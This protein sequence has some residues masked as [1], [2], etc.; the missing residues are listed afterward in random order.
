MLEKFRNCY[1]QGSLV[2]ELINIDRGLYIVRVS[3]EV[4]GVILAT[5]L[6]A[7][8][9]VETAE[10]RARVRAIETL[11]LEVEEASSK[12]PDHRDVPK[13][14]AS[15]ESATANLKAAK[16]GNQ[17]QIAASENLSVP[18]VSIL[19]EDTS[20][21][22]DSSVSP[23]V[24]IEST[25]EPTSLTPSLENQT[26]LNTATDNSE[27]LFAGTYDFQ[28]PETA[29]SPQ[30]SVDDGVSDTSVKIDFYAVKHETDIELQRLGWTSNEGRDFLKR[31]YG[32]PSR[33]RLTDE[34]L[35]E[36]LQHL[37]SLP[38]PE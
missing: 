2:G 36:F 33:L 3:I 13:I 11:K 21:A 20:P 4:E 5:G 32:K 38:T 29:T 23:V 12:I 14:Q 35:L 18:P 9:T 25:P 26:V 27:N 31:Q 8:D 28:A 1:P 24:E 7:A 22:N 16:N 30:P 37:K 34:E 6:A 17:N 10:D 19:L 15:T